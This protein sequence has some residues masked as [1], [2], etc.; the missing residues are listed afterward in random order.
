[1]ESPAGATPIRGAAANDVAPARG[2]V[3]IAGRPPGAYAARLSDAAASRLK[4]HLAIAT[5]MAKTAV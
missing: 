1:M 5:K 2:F 4:Q 3:E